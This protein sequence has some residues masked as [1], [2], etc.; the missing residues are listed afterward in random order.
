MT[1]GRW[2]PRRGPRNTVRWRN[3]KWTAAVGCGRDGRI[4]GSVQADLALT[5]SAAVVAVGPRRQGTADRF[6]DRLDIPNRHDSYQGW[7]P[8]L[9]WMWSTW[10]RHSLSTTEQHACVTDGEAGPGR[11]AVHHERR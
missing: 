1:S 5:D 3:D 4:C 7:S 9:R 6:A 10:R 11:E 8:T 2:F